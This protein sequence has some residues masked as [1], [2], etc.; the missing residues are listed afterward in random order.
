MGDINQDD[1][2]DISD[3]ILCLRQSIGLDNPDTSS[4]DMNNDG[5]VDISDVILVLR[6]A[7]GLD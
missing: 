3:V 5:T 6:K 7:I 2:I 1:I 4:A